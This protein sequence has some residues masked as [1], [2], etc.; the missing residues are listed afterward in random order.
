MFLIYGRRLLKE[1]Q[2]TIYL[3]QFEGCK[4]LIFAYINYKVLLKLYIYNKI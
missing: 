3:I 4:I 2:L 1:L